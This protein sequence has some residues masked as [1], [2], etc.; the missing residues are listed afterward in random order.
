M[1]NNKYYNKYNTF[2]IVVFITITF[3]TGLNGRKK[4]GN[5]FYLDYRSLPASSPSMGRELT[6]LA[7]Y[8]DRNNQKS[9][10]KSKKNKRGLLPI[11]NALLKPGE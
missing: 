1:I 3:C 10:K 4:L 7:S 2:I 6:S 11:D 5:S 8:N 9:L